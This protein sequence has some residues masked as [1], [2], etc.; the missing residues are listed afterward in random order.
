[1]IVVMRH[2]FRDLPAKTRYSHNNDIKFGKPLGKPTLA[3][4]N[5]KVSTENSLMVLVPVPWV[6]GCLLS[7]EQVAETSTQC[8]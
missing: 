1:M 6:V 8:K 2:F 4:E 7:V 5:K 3:T